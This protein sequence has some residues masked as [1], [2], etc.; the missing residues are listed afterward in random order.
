[1]V[2]GSG[3]FISPHKQKRNKD[4]KMVAIV[5]PF[6]SLMGRII[7]TIKGATEYLEQQGHYLSFHSSNRNVVSDNFQG[8]YMAADLLI[9]N[10]HRK[11]DYISGVSN[12]ETVVEKRREAAVL[13]HSHTLAPDYGWADGFRALVEEMSM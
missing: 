8:G 9:K 10:G 3:I 6:S 7:D 2:R 12:E 13:W 11:I 1:M 4:N 5:L